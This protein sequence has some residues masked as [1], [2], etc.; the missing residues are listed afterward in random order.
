M[1]VSCHAC[2]HRKTKKN[3]LSAMQPVKKGDGQGGCCRCGAGMSRGGV[4]CR[5][6]GF[7]TIMTVSLPGPVDCRRNHSI[8]VGR[9]YK[10]LI[11]REIP[12]TAMPV[13]SVRRSGSARAASLE[14]RIR[15]CSLSS[16]HDRRPPSASFSV[17]GGMCSRGRFRRQPVKNADRC[18]WNGKSPEPAGCDPVMV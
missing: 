12:R 17:P 11:K 8:A 7:P 15:T 2:K 3:D 10:L 4:L 9:R 6:Y 5:P 16:R 18:C 13:P 1:H 14:A